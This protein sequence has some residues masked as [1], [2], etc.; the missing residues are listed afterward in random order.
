MFVLGV[1]SL[2]IGQGS[3]RLTADSTP[4][5]Q[6]RPDTAATAKMGGSSA[7]STLGT[8]VAGLVATPSDTVRRRPKPVEVSE[9]YSRRLTIHRDVAYATIPVFAVQYAAGEQLYKK[10]SAAPTWAR[11]STGWAPRRWR[12]CSR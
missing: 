1:L 12:E 9:W 4:A 8:L 10:S 2:I 11:R 5:S 7:D 6:S 3:A